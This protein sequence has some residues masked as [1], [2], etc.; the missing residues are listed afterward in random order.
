MI[1]IEDYKDYNSI[2]VHFCRIC[3]SLKII[4]ISG[5]KDLNYCP[6]CKDVA[7][8]TTDIYTWKKLY[9]SKYKKDFLEGSNEAAKSHE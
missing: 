7:I 9:K 8:G 3:L 5:D 1:N 4:N 2:P 6:S